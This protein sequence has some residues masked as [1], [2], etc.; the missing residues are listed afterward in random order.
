MKPSAHLLSRAEYLIRWSRLSTL[1]YSVFH[2]IVSSESPLLL[3]SNP[4][5]VPLAA[6][7]PNCKYILYTTL[8]F[9]IA[10][11]STVLLFTLRIY[12]LYHNNIYVL[13]FFSLSWLFVLACALLVPIG[14][15][16]VPIG[17]TKYC[18][19]EKTPL[20]ATL[21]ALWIFIHDTLIF[22]ATSWI[23]MKYSHSTVTIQN[24]IEVLV[25]GKRLSAFSRSVLLD[26]QAYYLCAT[27]CSTFHQHFC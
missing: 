8:I 26:G 1:L 21:N 25:R 10:I 24:G 6:P 9:P 14:V 22:C 13:G 19:L 27:S 17:N 4:F 16:G 15:Q 5:S 12:A 2:V 23:F 3:R 20:S 7:L 18:L 11:P